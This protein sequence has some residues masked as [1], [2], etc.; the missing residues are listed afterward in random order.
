MRWLDGITDSMYVSVSKLWELV[1]D[2]EAWRA[3]VHGVAKSWT[4]LSDGTELSKHD[5]SLLNTPSPKVTY[6]ATLSLSRHREQTTRSHHVMFS[7]PQR[8]LLLLLSR[9]VVSDTLRPRG[10]QHSRLLCPSTFPS[11]CSD[12]CPLSWDAIQP[13]HLLPSPSPPA[14]N[15]SQHQGLF[16]V[17]RLFTSGGQSI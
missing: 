9:S 16:P 2:R 17:S 4:R 1:M 8:P 13:S 6:V 15:L 12:S 11:V 14:L 3:A 5:F 10:L 7:F